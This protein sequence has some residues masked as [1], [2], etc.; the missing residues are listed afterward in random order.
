M[1]NTQVVAALEQPRVESDAAPDSPVKLTG[2]IAALYLAPLPP[3]RPANLEQQVALLA[4]IPLPPIRPADLGAFAPS[5]AAPL[6]PAR[7]AHLALMSPDATEA[8]DVTASIIG[9]PRASPAVVAV[10]NGPATPPSAAPEPAEDL[11]NVITRGL[12]APPPAVLALVE[13]PPAPAADNG[14]LLSRAAALE[15]PLPP[16]PIPNAAPAPASSPAAPA[17]AKAGFIAGVARL[18]GVFRT[19]GGPDELRGPQQ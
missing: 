4:N 13:L 2:P 10:A 11:P 19:A 5:V 14:A 12:A 18:F 3:R 9:P 7:P 15:A 1:A 16:M 17:E 6:P 8:P